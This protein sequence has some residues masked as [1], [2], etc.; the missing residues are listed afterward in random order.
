M[1]HPAY[2][3]ALVCGSLL[4]F[5]GVANAQDD[6]HVYVVV[7]W[8]SIMPDGGTAE[9][10]DALLSEFIEAVLK[11]ND[12]ILS[13]KTLRHM[14][15]SNNHDWVVINEYASFAALAAAAELNEKL[16]EK[17]WPNEK[18]RTEFFRKLGKYFT[19]HADEIY[20]GI[21]KFDK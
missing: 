3:I 13:S 17:K 19:G 20:R 15:G 14:Y 2:V 8:E 7:T 21:P 12:K 5:S 11:K 18:K 4:L 6:G 16:S 9:E 1:K 10:R